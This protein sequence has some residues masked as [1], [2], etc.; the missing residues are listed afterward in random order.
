MN[1]LLNQISELMGTNLWLGL[2]LS[3]IAGVL[4]SFT[5][6]SLS[7]VSLV[8]GYVG[9]TNS[10]KARSLR[11]SLVFSL[12]IVIAFTTLGVI[13]SLL[14]RLLMGS[15]R[16]YYIVLGILMFLM[17]LQMFDLIHIMPKKCGFLSRSKKG[18]VGAFLLGLLGAVFSSPC[19]TPVLVA[20][21]SVVS[22]E[23]D[24]FAGTLML[25]L[26]SIGHCILLVVA[27]TMVGFVKDLSTSNKFQIA[28]KV[29]KIIMGGVMLLITY[30]MFYMA[31]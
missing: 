12:G 23:G 1:D 7:S 4:T 13:A 14:G 21:L 15:G 9:G 31:F 27:G 18:Y 10:S 29:L 30:Y 24:I 20:I 17:T 26:Y 16:W 19:S 3:L 22:S 6:C 28:S 25:L 8:I 11:L 5:P 2:L